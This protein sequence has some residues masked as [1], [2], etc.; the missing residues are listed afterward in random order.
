MSVPEKLKRVVKAKFKLPSTN[1]NSEI[2][3]VKVKRIKEKLQHVYQR[4]VDA[5]L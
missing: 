2:V 4:N 3:L 5:D 1:N